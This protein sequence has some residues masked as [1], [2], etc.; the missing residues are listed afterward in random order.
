MTSENYGIRHKRCN[1]ARSSFKKTIIYDF[2]PQ[3]FV[4]LAGILLTF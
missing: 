4:N 3:L 1:L 2:Q